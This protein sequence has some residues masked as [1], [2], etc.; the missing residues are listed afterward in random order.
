[1]IRSTSLIKG[2]GN[3]HQSE[4]P[5]WPSNGRISATL[6]DA[7][8]LCARNHRRCPDSNAC[9]VASFTNNQPLTAL[10]SEE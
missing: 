2:G 3:Y 4:L 6:A 1:M 8:N 10:Q 9:C 7:N 5:E